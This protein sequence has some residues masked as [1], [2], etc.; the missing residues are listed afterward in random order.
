MFVDDLGEEQWHDVMSVSDG[1]F[2]KFRESG[3]T[4][5]VFYARY[6]RIYLL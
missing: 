6:L 2:T 3:D 5:D 1:V 4:D